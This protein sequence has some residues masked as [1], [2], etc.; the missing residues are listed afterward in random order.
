MNN[1][2][3]IFLQ[4]AKE[5]LCDPEKK[6]NYDKWRNSGIAMSYK[7]WVGMKEHVQQVR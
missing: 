4:E 7:Q 6:A 1:C 2:F 3:S 5:I